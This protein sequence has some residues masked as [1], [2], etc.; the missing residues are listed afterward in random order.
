MYT[1]EWPSVRPE[2]LGHTQNLQSASSYIPIDASL[3]VHCCL[4]VVA[5]F[6]HLAVFC[7]RS[8]SDI[9]AIP[10]QCQY[11]SKDVENTI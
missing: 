5:M 1:Y 7:P 3:L 8:M 9:G 10:S 2:V 11:V 4:P 6:W